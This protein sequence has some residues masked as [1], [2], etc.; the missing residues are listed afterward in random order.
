MPL[1]KELNVSKEVLLGRS[2][3]EHGV[4]AACTTTTALAGALLMAYGAVALSHAVTMPERLDQWADE[5]KGYSGPLFIAV[6][7]AYR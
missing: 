2:I 3:Y 6:F 4:R 5:Y 1:L 7:V